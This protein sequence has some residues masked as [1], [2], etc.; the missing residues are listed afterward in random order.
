LLCE[1]HGFALP[2]VLAQHVLLLRPLLAARVFSWLC[3]SRVDVDSH[4]FME[5]LQQSIAKGD[6]QSVHARPAR[7]ADADC[8]PRAGELAKCKKFET[9]AKQVAKKPAPL[10]PLAQ[11]RCASAAC[12]IKLR[13]TVADLAVEHVQ[14][15]RSWR[16]RRR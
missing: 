7:A 16:R 15:R 12:F 11:A 14:P 8:R 6:E 10:N 5:A 3:C 2:V 4:R 13:C 1:A 9:W